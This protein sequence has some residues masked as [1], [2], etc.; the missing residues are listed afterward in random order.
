MTSAATKAGW[1]LAIPAVLF[2]LLCFVA[3][4]AQTLW[5]GFG[6]R[7]DAGVMTY[8]FTFENYRR[9]FATDLYWRILLRTAKM[10][11]WA[12]CVAAIVGFPLA[13]VVARG[14]PWLSRLVTLTLVT[15][16]LVN[17]V[18]R[19]YG[20][21]AI[22][23]RN[24]L[25]SW[26]LGG[27][28][29]E[30]PPSILYTE[31]A[32]LIASVHVFLPFMVLPLAGAIARIP[33]SAEQAATIAGAGP[34]QRFWR[35]ILPLSLPGLAVG[36]P[37]VFS[38]TAAAYVTPQILGGNFSPLLGTLIQQQVLT[39]HDWPFGAALSTLLVAM[40]LAVNLVFIGIVGRR[41]RRWTAVA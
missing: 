30:D 9:A 22:L 10:A 34:V 24:G 31:A 39:L 27:L 38:L 25:I 23:S 36:L 37:L 1:L 8:G 16:L 26:T 11:T 29:I 28:G 4:V 6:A 41:L 35:I 33:P 18:V 15:P 32:V 17:V 19:S 14:R 2:L 20:W 21:S 40:V 3:P 7:T 13:W 5:L 12:A